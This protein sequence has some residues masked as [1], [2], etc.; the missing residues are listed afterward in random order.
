MGE[1]GCEWEILDFEGNAFVG[2]ITLAGQ[3]ERERVP[4][5]NGG[6]YNIRWILEN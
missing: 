1:G 3:R 6:F 2:G 5:G 4:F